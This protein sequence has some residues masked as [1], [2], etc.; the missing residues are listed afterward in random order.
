MI[1]L[2]TWCAYDLVADLPLEKIGREEAEADYF[3]KVLPLVQVCLENTNQ[4]LET[5]NVWNQ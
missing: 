3:E 4:S 5:A 2:K 1:V